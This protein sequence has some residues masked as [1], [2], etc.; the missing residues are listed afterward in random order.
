M[1]V[2]NSEV[3]LGAKEIDGKYELTDSNDKKI[4]IDKSLLK[5]NGYDIIDNKVIIS[6][7]LYKS[8]FS[9]LYNPGESEN[10]Q[11]DFLNHLPKILENKEFIYSDSRIFLC[12]LYFATA[13]STITGSSFFT[14]GGLLQSWE[15]TELDYICPECGNVM[16]IFH[17]GG[18]LLSGSN[19]CNA[20]CSDCKD[21]ISFKNHAFGKYY[22]IVADKINK[23]L[24]PY[25]T[26][27]YS[28]KEVIDL[29]L[30]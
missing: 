29:M 17:V 11:R 19:S 20:Y 6:L 9:K 15:G 30:K 21:I 23:Y 24:V 10:N 2:D 26:E 12:K 22:M 5:D 18:S 7:S 28:F 27:R 14:L 8:W 4:I 16:K 25:N 3:S 1:N 13:S